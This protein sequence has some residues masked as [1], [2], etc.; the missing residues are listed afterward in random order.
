MPLQRLS[1]THFQLDLSQD[2]LPPA[3]VPVEIGN[4]TLDFVGWLRVVS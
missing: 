2:C 3:R 1:K 4:L